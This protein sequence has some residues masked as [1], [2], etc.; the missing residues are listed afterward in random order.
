MAV[1]LLQRWNTDLRRSIDKIVRL[2]LARRRVGIVTVRVL[3]LD[4]PVLLENGELA[5]GIRLGY[6]LSRRNSVSLQDVARQHLA[7]VLDR[8]VGPGWDYP[9][10]LSSHATSPS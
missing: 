3:V 6:L 5:G 1:L 7:F 2:G 4:G 9:V 10:S 8:P